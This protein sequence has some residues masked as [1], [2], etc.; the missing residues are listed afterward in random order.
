MNWD[1]CIVLIPMNPCGSNPAVHK[2]VTDAKLEKIMY[3]MGLLKKYAKDDLV[4][5]EGIG[6]KI[7]D[8]L[9]KEGITT[10]SELADTPVSRLQSIMQQA[11]DRFQLADPSTWP[12]QAAMARDGRWKELYA[13]Q[14]TLKGG[15]EI[16]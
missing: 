14:D 9:K 2:V 16:K 6:P 1:S 11:G 15:K 3:K 12:Q 4:A 7:S 5:V 8:I 10:W 13:Y